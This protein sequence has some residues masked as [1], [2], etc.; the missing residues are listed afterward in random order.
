MRMFEPIVRS[1]KQETKQNN[2][3]ASKINYMRKAY[4]SSVNV[5]KLFNDILEG[6]GL[7]PI[8]FSQKPK[9][10]AEQLV[11]AQ[12]APRQI[13]PPKVGANLEEEVIA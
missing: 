8:D 5:L 6:S 11:P 3:M 10:T 2:A 4:T 7:S 13:A 1:V 9:K 12:A